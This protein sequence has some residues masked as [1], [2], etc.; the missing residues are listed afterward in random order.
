LKGKIFKYYS[1]INLDWGEAIDASPH[2][3]FIIH[4]GY[5]SISQYC[6]ALEK[7]TFINNNLILAKKRLL[8][9]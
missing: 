1:L 7:G 4:E 3:S 5:Q 9:L 2:F 6:P 8:W